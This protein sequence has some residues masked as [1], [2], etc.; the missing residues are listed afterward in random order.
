M[1]WTNTLKNIKDIEFN[2]HCLL[3]LFGIII[4]TLGVLWVLIGISLGLYVLYILD[5]SFVDSLSVFNPCILVS[6]FHIIPGAIIHIVS[7]N[8]F[9]EY[10]K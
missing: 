3:F 6:V 7:L 5:G 8:Y 9:Q 10:E 1:D 4:I 2:S